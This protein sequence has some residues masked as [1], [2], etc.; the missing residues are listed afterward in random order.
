MIW[1]IFVLML[2]A[3]IVCVALPLY[4]SQRRVSATNA[5]AIFIVVGLSAVFYQQLGTPGAESATSEE[6]SVEDMVESLDA[7][8]RQKPGD[9]AGWKMLG[10][11]YLQMRN[12][13]G[14][15][16]AFEHAVEL[17]S[18]SDGRTLADL[19][20]AVLLQDQSSINGRAVELFESSLALVPNNPKALF[21]AGMIAMNR[22][23]NE[24]AADRWEA[25]L[26][27]SPPANVQ[28]ILRPKIAELRGEAPP[29]PIPAVANDR[30]S[31][32]TV[33]V[34]LGEAAASAADANA[35]VFVIARDPEQPSPPIA[36]VRRKV[37]ELPDEVTI[38]DADAMI[39]GR[40]PSAFARLEIVARVSM[41]GQPMA[42]SGDWF[43]SA[44]LEMANA[45]GIDIT[46]DQSVP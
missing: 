11:S 13:D 7:R 37:S 10:R 41:S 14:A 28:E 35:T 2:L 38:A 4:R 3:A 6:P 1:L 17:E 5:G 42:Q 36:A 32:V 46:I 22:G 23:N 33:R 8:L 9:L 39:P 30:P 21:Y 26:A 27:T 29:M 15:V 31:G 40:V 18:S 45:D 24:L 44:I 25:L 34:S 19:G 43:G 12:F 16:D 20:E